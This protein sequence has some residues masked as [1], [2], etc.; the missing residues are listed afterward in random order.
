MWFKGAP[1]ENYTTSFSFSLEKLKHSSG[2]LAAQLGNL[3]CLSAPWNSG[4]ESLNL[5]PTLALF[6]EGAA[7]RPASLFITMTLPCQRGLD[8]CETD[9]RQEPVAHSK[10]CVKDSNQVCLISKLFTL[11]HLPL[12]NRTGN[13]GDDV[14]KNNSFIHSKYLLRVYDV[15]VTD[16]QMLGIQR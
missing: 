14:E 16:A 5:R 11:F 15:P 12:L 6:P 4:G 7:S 9:A 8:T 1:T 3:N 10:S 2:S 13:P